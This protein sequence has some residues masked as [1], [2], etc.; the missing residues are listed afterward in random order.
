[1]LKEFCLWLKTPIIYQGGDPVERQ[2]INIFVDG[3]TNDQ[4]NMKIL[5]D[6]PEAI[7]CAVVFATNEQNLRTHDCTISP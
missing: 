4:L 5:R 2:L 7:Q 1:M 6:Q 3:L